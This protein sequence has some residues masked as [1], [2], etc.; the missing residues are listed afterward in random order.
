M[1]NLIDTAAQKH[2]QERS[3]SSLSELYTALLSG[4]MLVPI[5]ANATADA[6]GRLD[7]PARCLRLPTGEGCLPAFTSLDHLLE[8]DRNDPKYIE[9][10]GRAIFEMASAMPEVDC[11]YVNY[12]E[13]SRAPKGK[14]T[15]PEIALLAR[16]IMPSDCPAPE[17]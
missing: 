15:R 6:A 4:R 8:W 9:L 1:R 17:D 3:R 12:S 7:V 5:F 11:I 16:G 14:V 10:S 2:I 13:H